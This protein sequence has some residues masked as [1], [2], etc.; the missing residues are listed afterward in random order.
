M[1][2]IA[3]IKVERDYTLYGG[4]AD[5]RDDIL[6]G[7]M[8]PETLVEGPS[9]TG[10]SLGI[11]L[12]LAGL[13]EEQPGTKVLIVRKTLKSMRETVLA[14]WEDEVLP[15]GH[16]ALRANNRHSQN[17]RYQ[18]NNG[19]LAVAT[20]CNGPDDIERIKSSEW[21]IIWFN[22]ATD[23]TL[24]D[25]ETL[26]TR[27]SGKAPI[28]RFAI[29][30]CNPV[31][32]THWL[33]RRAS[34]PKMR[35]VKTTLDDNPRF[36]DQRTGEYT[37]DGM[38]YLRVLDNLTGVRKLRLRHGLWAVAEGAIWGNFNEDVHIIDAAIKP[39][40]QS[41][42][43]ELRFNDGRVVPL[44]WFFAGVDWGWRAPG[45]LLVFGIDKDRNAYCIHEIYM[46]QKDKIW[47][48]EKAEKLRRKYDIQ[49]F[50]CD[51]AE[52]DSI[53]LFNKRMG[54]VGGHWIAQPVKKHALGFEASASIVRERLDRGGL[55]FLRDCL[56]EIDPLLV[57][58]RKPVS[59]LEEIP[60]YEYHE[61]KDGQPIKEE[62][63]KD[64]DDHGCD[65]VRYGMS[66]LDD[67]NWQ[68]VPEES[69]FKPG[70]FGRLLGHDTMKFR[71][72]A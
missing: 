14:T 12:A 58:E 1:V 24:N 35:R 9:R 46:T 60:A 10:K 40:V 16:E 4:L 37:E 39:N 64:G 31:A 34:T 55:F 42:F 44:T 7:R 21:D 53:D 29:A 68:P 2:A 51:S 23:G 3:N 67:N 61:V 41:G 18:F 66:F 33:N 54:K 11:G 6:S 69:K 70:S 30:D 32:K 22:E 17:P 25:W 57:E 27:L 20:G 72:S 45:C 5:V 71:R 26:L 63:R 15:S 59:V 49:R 36:V 50:V 47:W 13:M 38:R 62:P 43:Y 8:P 52:P 48:A 65:A 28:G 56:D 19:S